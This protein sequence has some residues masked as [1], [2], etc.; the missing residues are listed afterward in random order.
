[1]K[2]IRYLESIDL[3]KSV[4]EKQPNGVNTKTYKKIE[5]YNVVKK[6][7]DDEVNATLYGANINKMYAIS[8]PLGDLEK[9]LI[10]KVD[11]VEDNISLYYIKI[12][13]SKYKIVSVVSN[14][15]KIERL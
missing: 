13:G 8:T 11:N 4:R 10:P 12:G 15:I 9:Y 2:L 7:L 5:S 14:Q 1:M 6:T 3:L